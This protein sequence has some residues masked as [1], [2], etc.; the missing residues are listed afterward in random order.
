MNKNNQQ[1]SLIKRKVGEYTVS[2][3]II[4]S[5]HDSCDTIDFFKITDYKYGFYLADVAGQ[6][7]NAINIMNKLQELINKNCF[8]CLDQKQECILNPALIAKT[9]NNAMYENNLSKYVTLIYGILDTAT[10]V[11]EYTTAGYYPNPILL[12]NNPQIK[13]NKKHKA[14]KYLF[15]KGFPLGILKDAN[16]DNFQ[17]KIEKNSSIIFF[18]DGIMNF[19]KPDSN[20]SKDKDD[21]LLNL[22]IK[23][24]MDISNIL[25]QLNLNYSVPIVDDI[26]VLTIQR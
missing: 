2:Y 6:G 15:S 18:S 24:N 5:I 1:Y 25:Q 3:G 19:F 7:K 16:F 10:N 4:Q 8:E 20:N 11:I 14:A 9:I 12:N 17:V 26:V 22:T 13:D 23:S 21:E